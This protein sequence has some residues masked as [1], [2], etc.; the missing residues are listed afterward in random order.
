M[1]E[2]SNACRDVGTIIFRFLTK[3]H[4][5]LWLTFPSTPLHIPLSDILLL[6]FLPSTSQS[7]SYPLVKTDIYISMIE[8][9]T[10]RVHGAQHLN[11]NKLNNFIT[12][13]TPGLVPTNPVLTT[14]CFGLCIFYDKI[15]CLLL[16][17]IDWVSVY[18][19]VS[20]K[21]Q[22]SSTDQANIFS[23]TSHDPREGLWMLKAAKNV[24]ESFWFL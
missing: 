24:F 7:L 3:T 19:F 18:L 11:L 16:K 10:H 14:F 21:W 17:S 2:I 23:G 9:F 8:G 5:P 22:N 15:N 6:L 4:S 20:I 13:L 1:F 12:F